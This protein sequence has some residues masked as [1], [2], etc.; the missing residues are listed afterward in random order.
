MI[1][2]INISVIQIIFDTISMIMPIYF[3]LATFC[4]VV[5]A[6]QLAA[7]L[8]TV[9]YKEKKMSFRKLLKDKGCRGEYRTS[10]QFEKLIPNAK[11]IF[12]AYI[13][14]NETETTEI[15]IIVIS[16]YGIYVV[17]NK[18]YKGWIFGDEKSQKWCQ[19]LSKKKKFFFY[20]PIKQNNTHI[21]SLRALLKENNLEKE[22]RS[23]VCFNGN[24]VFKKMNV[25]SPNIVVTKSA[26]L[27]KHIDKSVEYI[28]SEEVHKIYTLLKPYTKVSE[29]KKQQHIDGI[30]SK[31]K[32]EQNF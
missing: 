12:N 24:A 23:Y 4:I 17:E 14:K 6:Y 3:V 30:K 21:E 8:N 22:I 13:S 20:N 9:Y 15:D 19:H 7:Y 25:S 27:Y 16:K 5:Y 28:T 26:D 29:D 32:N 11:M 10:Q 1:N 31:Y 18:N 2:Y